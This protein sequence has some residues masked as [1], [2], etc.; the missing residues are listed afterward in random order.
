MMNILALSPNDWHG[1]WVNRQQLLSRLASTWPVLY[2]TGA[3]S[4]WDR[5]T[6]AYRAAPLLGKTDSADGVQL[7]RPGRWPPRWPTRP[8]WDAWAL[9]Q[10]A[11]RLR[12]AF[13]DPAAPLVAYLCHP[14]YWPY[15]QALKPQFVVYHCYDL[16]ERQPGW[17]PAMDTAERSLL[18]R[19]DLVFS[20]TRMLSDLLQAKAPCQARVLLNAADVEAVFA[21]ERAAAPE[22]ADLAAIPHPRIGYVGSIHPQL[23]LELIAT[24]ARRCPDWH[25]VL[26]GPEQKAD[27]LHANAGY[28]ALRGLANVHLLGERHRSRVPGYLLGMDANVMFYKAGADSWT[29]VAYPLKLHEYLACGKPVVSVALK[30]I[31]EFDGLITFADGVDAWQ[32][33]LDAALRENDPDLRQRRR[34]AAAMNSWDHRVVQLRGWL[35]QLAAGSLQTSSPAITS[36]GKN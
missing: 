3:W 18:A 15:V 25:F 1:Q 8:G 23:D 20:P 36:P 32:S 27:D 29:Q 14:S 33:G 30:M 4:V 2:S 7:D 21:A 5:S 22:P 11:A 28:R 12:R 24:L 13:A 9:R 19:A 35:Q 6:D 16:Y 34:A 31:S 10:H 17:T 26:I